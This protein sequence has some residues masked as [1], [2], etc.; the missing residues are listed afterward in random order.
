MVRD[1]YATYGLPWSLRYSASS[2]T[3]FRALAKAQAKT[4]I[5]TCRVD[6]VPFHSIV[7]LAPKLALGPES[8][9][10]PGAR[11]HSVNTNKDLMRSVHASS[12]GVHELH[13][14]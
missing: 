3:S 4:Y 10:K 5:L 13:N 9:S 2:A 6:R 11:A 1:S 8:T 12:T 7:L 14:E